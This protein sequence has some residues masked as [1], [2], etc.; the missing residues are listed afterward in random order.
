MPYWLATINSAFPAVELDVVLSRKAERFVTATTIQGLIG[1]RPY[2]EDGDPFQE[3]DG[4]PSHLVLAD[5]D[6]ILLCPA[7]PRILIEVALGS[8]T[9]PVTRVAAFAEPSRVAIA[10]WIHPSLDRANYVEYLERARARGMHV[11][12]T[13]SLE[14][15]DSPW[16][17]VLRQ[18]QALV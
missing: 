2:L 18:L 1:R 10:P 13:L 6:L 5:A 7:T 3:G 17:T 16:P 9:C 8:I 4:R 15:G 14:R 11:L 12:E